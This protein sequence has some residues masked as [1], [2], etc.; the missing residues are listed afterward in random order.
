M[1]NLLPLALGVLLLMQG[2]PRLLGQT[3]ASTPNR[4][5]MYD[6]KTE[7][8]VSGTVEAVKEAN[9]HQGWHGTHLEFKTADG[10]LDVHVGPSWFLNKQ[11][12]TIAKGDQLTVTGSKVR[13]NNADA[14][15]ART[16]KK[17]DS[18]ITLRNAQGIPAWSRGG[19]Y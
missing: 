18:E 12:F 13:Y 6:T 14:L 5:P 3:T 9:S 17:G 2:A 19:R 15:I 4:Q 11:K 10:T 1:F 16:I 8:T 7:A